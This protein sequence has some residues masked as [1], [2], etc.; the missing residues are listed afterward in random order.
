MARPQMNE[1]AL[2]GAAM[3]ALTGSKA[4]PDLA[5][6]SGALLGDIRVTEPAAAR[7]AFYEEKY[8]RYLRGHDSAMELCREVIGAR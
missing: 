7:K 1:S 4:F 5:H 2:M 6:A 3:L 8:A